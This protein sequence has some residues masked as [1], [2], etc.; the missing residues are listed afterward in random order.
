MSTPQQYPGVRSGA[1]GLALVLLC[2]QMLGACASWDAPSPTEPEE[3][4]LVV[5]GMLQAGSGE[6]EIIVEYTRPIR[7][8]YY[9]GLTPASGLQVVVRAAES[10]TFAEDPQHPGL[11]RASFV[12]RGGQRYA[13]EVRGPEGQT[14]TGETLIPE[15]IRLS[16]PS[17]DTIV[18]RGEKVT[19]HWTSAASAKAYVLVARLP[20][21]PASTEDVLTDKDILADTVLVEDVEM[22]GLLRGFAQTVQYTVA[23][24]DANYAGYVLSA[25][26]GN[27]EGNRRR[28][29]KTV[30]G[31]YG[32]FGAYALS[33]SRIIGVQ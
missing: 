26:E 8:G 23:A 3:R 11:Y 17:R 30:Q 12:P 5:H 6:Q 22:R 27:A 1:G 25:P 21:R 15:P 16:L 29:R 4:H 28:I 19:L 13:L 10:H 14:V 9:R 18:K 33:N 24:V 7:D 20:G 32:L 2:F 31:G